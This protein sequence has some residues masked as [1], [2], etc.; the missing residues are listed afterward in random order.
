[1][2]PPS[3][4]NRHMA[5][6]AGGYANTG[7]VA[8]TAPKPAISLL[9]RR[10]ERNEWEGGSKETNVMRGKAVGGTIPNRMVDG[11]ALPS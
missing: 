3:P 2:A 9:P 10:Q 5:E 8:G 4:R 11:Q 6:A 1:M 7:R